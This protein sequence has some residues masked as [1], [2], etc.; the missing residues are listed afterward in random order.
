MKSQRTVVLFRLNVL[1]F[2]LL[3]LGCVNASAA[4]APAAVDRVTQAVD[5]SHRIA[6][7]ESRPA[8]VAPV[9]EVGAVPD[10]LALTHLS[11]VLKRSPERQAAFEALLAEQQDP[12]SPNYHRWLSPTEVGERYGVSTHDIEAVRAWLGTQGLA[13]DAV[14]NGRT[15]I[16]FSGNAAAVATTFAT[17]LRYY[18]A[19]TD[20][21]IA[22]TNDAEIPLALAGVVAS[23]Q[24]LQT[25]R[26]R[27]ALRMQ[28]PRRASISQPDGTNCPNVPGQPCDHTIFPSDFN[29]IYDL[30]PL[31]ARGIDG[32]GQTIAVI[33]RSRVYQP[34]ID[35]FTVQAELSMP[36]PTVII[37]PDGIDPGPPLSTCPDD[38]S[39][40][41]GNP[42][43]QVNDQFESTLDVQR[44]SSAAPGAAI[45]LIISDNL[46]GQDGVNIALEY[47]VNHDPVPA[48]IISLS[49]SSCEADNGRSVA[50]GVDDFFSQA[51]AEGISV[52][53]ASGDA[54]VAGCASLDSPP[55]AGEPVT[56][57]VLCSQYVTCVGGT[58]F[59]DHANPDLYWNSNNAEGFLSARGYI[60]EGAWNEPLDHDGDPQLAATGGGV[61]A[62]LPTPSWQAG[63][64]VPGHAGRYTPDVSLSAATHEGYF[65]CIAA[66]G[67]GCALVDGGFTY[68]PVGGTS[69]STPGLAAIGALLNQKTGAAQGNLNPRLYAL[70]AD[71]GA[72]AFHDVTV[73]TSGVS[74]C[75]LA[76]PSMCNNSVPGTSGLTGGIP[77]YLVGNGFDLA[78]GL[79]SVDAAHLVDNWSAS[80]AGPVNLDQVGLT[81]SWYN[82]ATSGQ[83]VVMEVVPDL[84][85]AGEGLLFGGWF[86]WDVTAAGGQRWYSVQGSVSA[87]AASATM[88]IYI[89]EG[90]NFAAPPR[91]GVSSVGQA[92]FSFGDCSHGTLSYTFS[93][94]SGRSGSIPLTRLG[95]NSACSSDG[96]GP[97][98]PT[99]LLSGAWYDPATSGQGLVF[100][101][102]PASNS[103]FLAWYTYA[104]DGQ[105]IGGP[106]SQRWYS[107]QATYT[108]GVSHYD[109]I[110]IYGTTGGVFN[111][112]TPVATA[113]IGTASLHFQS[114]AAATLTY[115][116]TSG[117]NAGKQGSIS[118]VRATPAVDGCSL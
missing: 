8:W 89:S 103:M 80:A 93:D 61:S 19:G 87:T 28:A 36:T 46:N 68:I 98:P 108:P 24:G 67:G 90:G 64:G 38:S 78:T 44:A 9:N 117:E 35:N 82:P 106:S 18:R 72:A 54:G 86:T 63:T 118:L 105:A 102:N 111:N 99:F 115:H 23:V 10:N 41:C 30:T 31:R 114:C 92:T 79:G 7:T 16:N 49:Y 56:T 74:G 25:V 69:A 29:V 94:G 95:A 26:Y 65:S 6:L 34:D 13:V 20:R 77:G 50:E 53:V 83:G 97:V 91:V 71:T 100:D 112:A 85:G 15:R 57:N 1:W 52:F 27:P 101:I 66:L 48:K 58:E 33:G 60:P 76:V 45:D 88:P 96:N 42:S 70:A 51:A 84:N 2:V 32:H 40:T 59:A 55:S 5:S 14:S 4:T 21:R 22:N 11:L 75:S 107:I 3:L 81:G 113:S 47:A 109:N 73:A 12:A 39:S 62:Y 37:P 104:V 43:D 116:F 17:S 110:A